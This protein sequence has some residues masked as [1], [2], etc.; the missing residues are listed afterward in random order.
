[1]NYLNQAIRK[2]DKYI[3]IITFSVIILKGKEVDQ[4]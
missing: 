1:M 4:P 3:M 2:H